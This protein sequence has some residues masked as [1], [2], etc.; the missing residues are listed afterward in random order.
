MFDSTEAC[1][2]LL[3]WAQAKSIQPVDL[4]ALSE[5]GIELMAATVK[6]YMNM[7]LLEEKCLQFHQRV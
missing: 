6:Q 3:Q 1:T 2:A 7:S 4:E 5:A